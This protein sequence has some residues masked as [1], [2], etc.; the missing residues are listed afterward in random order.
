MLGA[1]ENLEAICFQKHRTWKVVHPGICLLACCNGDLKGYAWQNTEPR[2]AKRCSFF[3]LNAQD[4][5]GIE[6]GMC[7]SGFS[8]KK[9]IFL[10]SN[11]KCLNQKYNSGK[12][13]EH[14]YSLQAKQHI[15]SSAT[16][17]DEY[18]SSYRSS[19]R[20]FST[21]TWGVPISPFFKGF[22]NISQTIPTLQDTQWA[23]KRQTAP[24]WCVCC[25]P[26]RY[27]L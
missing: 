21:Q 27:A 16:K 11:K 14:L 10:P 24:C 20:Q 25:V 7:T 2:E 3:M 19:Y 6:P 9:C 1:P 15:W 23:Q 17:P 13:P 4:I 5:I 18:H 26:E 12:V 8:M 22:P